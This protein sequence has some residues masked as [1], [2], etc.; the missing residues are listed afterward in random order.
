MERPTVMHY[1]AVK[2]ILR[3]VKG[4]LVY[5]RRGVGNYILSD[6]SDSYLI[7]NIDDRKSTGGMAFY[8]NENLIT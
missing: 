8:L 7:G 2:H 4:T 3:Y 6:Y 1:N 5:Y